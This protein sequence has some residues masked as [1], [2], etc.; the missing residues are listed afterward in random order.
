M[1]N[2]M[3]EATE[4]RMKCAVEQVLTLLIDDLGIEPFQ[5]AS[6]PGDAFSAV[7]VLA[8]SMVLAVLAG[9]SKAGVPIPQL[10]PKSEIGRICG[11]MFVNHD[12]H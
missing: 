9:L 4:Q 7:D 6:E 8:E 1:K 11:Q 3:S 12:A 5:L 10:P 2:A